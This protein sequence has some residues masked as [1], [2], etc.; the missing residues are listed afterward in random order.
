MHWAKRGWERLNLHTLNTTSWQ[1][2]LPAMQGAMRLA[3][4]HWGRRATVHLRTAVFKS[5]SFQ[6]AMNGFSAMSAG[7]APHLEMPTLWPKAAYIL[8]SL[9]HR[10][11]HGC[12]NTTS[13]Q[14]LN[15][16]WDSHWTHTGISVTFITLVT[17]QLRGSLNSS[18]PQR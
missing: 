17:S 12:I 10:W 11:V 4:R 5:V 1:S 3:C 15:W 8:E 13:V 2:M 14:L 18:G 9:I 16:V 6:E 7:Y